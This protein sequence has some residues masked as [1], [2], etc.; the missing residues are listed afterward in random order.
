[1]TTLG[2]TRM[3]TKTRYLQALVVIAATSLLQFGPIFLTGARPSP[4][5]LFP[6]FLVYPV[7]LVC[8][9]LCVRLSSSSN[10]SCF[11][12]FATQQF[13]GSVAISVGSVSSVVYAAYVIVWILYIFSSVIAVLLFVDELSNLFIMCHKKGE[14]SPTTDI[15][16]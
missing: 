8:G 12:F 16:L 7:H 1:M 4:L 10:G 14:D 9:T 11:A 6:E 3:M 5:D 13:L 2:M 15:S